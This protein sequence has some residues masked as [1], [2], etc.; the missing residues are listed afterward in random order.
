MSDQLTTDLFTDIVASNADQVQ[1]RV[2]IPRV[3]NRILL[4]QYGNFQN[5]QP[6]MLDNEHTEQHKI[7]QYMQNIPEM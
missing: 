3:V 1:Y 7:Q 6:T 2:H 4:R 5:L